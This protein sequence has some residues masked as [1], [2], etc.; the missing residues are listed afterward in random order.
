MEPVVLQ[1]PVDGLLGSLAQA[2]VL[3][4]TLLLVMM[5]VALGV[6]AYKHLRGDGIEWPEDKESTPDSVTDGVSKG[7]S[8][9]EWDYY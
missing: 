2:A 5:L 6:Y 7:D 3:M 8:D 4:A 1:L 9:D